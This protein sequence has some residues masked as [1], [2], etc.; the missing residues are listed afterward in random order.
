MINNNIKI[1]VVEDEYVQRLLLT[2]YLEK[3]DIQNVLE[4]TDG[5]NAVE[6]CRDNSDIDLILMNIGMPIM[7]GCEATTEIRKF[8]KDIIIIANTIC[9]PI[10]K[11]ELMKYEFND[12]MSKPILLNDLYN[13][14]EKYFFI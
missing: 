4:A 5:K 8:N 10:E 9:N 6:I 1:L 12:V 11:N 7:N 13:I 3:F 14:I 2:T